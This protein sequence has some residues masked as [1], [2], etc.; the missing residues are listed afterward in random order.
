MKLIKTEVLVVGSGFGAAAP[1]LRLCQAGFEV[2][3]I[4]KGPN[5]IPEQDFKM[6]QD[7]KY[8]LKYL[9]GADAKNISFTYAE[10]LGGGSG[11][12]EMVSLRAPSRVFEQR[13]QEKRLYW[14]TIINRKT[15]DPYYDIAERILNVEQIPVEEIPK[16]GIVFSQMM[17]NLGYS[18]ERARYAVKGCAGS[19]YCI[20]GCVFG[21]KQ[22]L[23]LN[24]LPQ[25]KKFGLKILTDIEALEIYPKLAN[26]N[27]TKYLYHIA[28]IPYRYSI[29][30]K[31]RLTDE[32]F[33]IE[34][35]LLILGGGTIGSAKLL[36]NSK[37]HLHFLSEHLG[38]GIA[39]NGSI[40]AAGLLP[41]GFIEGD[42]FSGRSHPGMIS[43]QFFDKLGIT[44]SSAK[45]LPLFALGAAR[46]KPESETRNP[47]YWGQANVELM[48]KYRKRLIILYSLGLTPPSAEIKME[49]NGEVKPNLIITNE[50]RKYYNDTLKLLHSI[51]NRN[52]CEVVDIGIVD[53]EGMLN[54]EISYSTAHM[55]GSCRMAESNDDGVVNPYGELFNYPG[56]F[57]TDGACIP[58]SLAVNTSLTIL[59]NAE[60]IADYLVQYFKKSKKLQ[61]K[62]LTDKI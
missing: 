13:D 37:K 23:H 31:N 3:M 20:T 25:A 59:A 52:G 30:C 62:I 44:I 18:C 1:A 33:E 47:S 54:S 6:T 7:P 15:L 50:L 43:Y 11:F 56:I 9:K 46:L 4:E 24:Y 45:P 51:F 12:Y 26:S 10:A 36:L 19:G 22:S 29:K 41:D 49:A 38:K 61:N 2:L 28:G 55:V 16:S 57:V 60:R 48:K 14:P 8:L 40:K 34:T 5:V 27:S 42:M 17:K 21:A 35:K 32:L 53:K 39:F 58:T